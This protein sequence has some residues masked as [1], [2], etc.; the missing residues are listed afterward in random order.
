MPQKICKLNLQI[1]CVFSLKTISLLDGGDCKEPRYM[2][3]KSALFI[4]AYYNVLS[5]V[6]YYVTR[7]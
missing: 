2:A 3:Q 1:F 6:Y 7:A 5:V 4:S